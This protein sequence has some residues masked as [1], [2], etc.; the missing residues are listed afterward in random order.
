MPLARPGG[1]QVARERGCAEPRPGR[2]PQ[3]ACSRENP[4]DPPCV[5]GPRGAQVQEQEA[6]L[7]HL[8]RLGQNVTWLPRTRSL[9]NDSLAVLSTYVNVCAHIR[10]HMYTHARM[11]VSVGVCVYIYL[12]IYIHILDLDAQLN[13]YRISFFFL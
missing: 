9:E 13:V 11:Y 1:A 3:L 5:R 6:R 10:V 8:L 2:P 4:T 12:C 7:E